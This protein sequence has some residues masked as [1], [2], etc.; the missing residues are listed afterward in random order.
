MATKKKTGALTAKGKNALLNGYLDEKGKEASRLKHELHEK[1]IE[2]AAINWYAM[3]RSRLE[4]V[5]RVTERMANRIE[6]EPGC[7]LATIFDADEL[8]DFAG[9]LGDTISYL[10]NV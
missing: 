2:Q 7:H 3:A 4:E 10:Q 5:Q 8:N 9:N 1:Q 6:K